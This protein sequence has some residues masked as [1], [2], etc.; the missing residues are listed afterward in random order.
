MRDDQ[1]KRLEML[2]EKLIDAAVVEMDPDFWPGSYDED[3]KLKRPDQLTKDERGDRYWCKKN[4]AQT[5]TLIMKVE[6]LAHFRDRYTP[7]TEEEMEDTEAD[8]DKEIKK[9]EKKGEE[10]LKKFQAR[11]VPAGHA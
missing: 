2:Q 7:R 4:A 6:S 10:L 8:I 3:G 5:M 9:H 11:M 1:L